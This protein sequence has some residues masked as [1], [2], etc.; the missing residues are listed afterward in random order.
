VDN[1]HR[2][3]GIGEMLMRESEVWAKNKGYQEVRLRSGGQRKE[4][5]EFYK[6]IGY[7]NVK[8]QEVFSL[9]LNG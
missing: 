2:R 6:R 9:K 3:K 1:Q 7:K 8:W 4:A 5:H